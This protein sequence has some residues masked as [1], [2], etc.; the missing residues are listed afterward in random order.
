[1]IMKIVL[2]LLLAGGVL[3]VTDRAQAQQPIK[4]ECS[5]PDQCFYID[6]ELAAKMGKPSDYPQYASLGKRFDTNGERAFVF[7]PRYKEWAAY[8]KEGYL[9]A[10]GVA[11][12][13]A[14]SCPDLGGR[15][16][17]TPMGVFRV[18]SKGSPE[19]V[20]KKFPIG[21]G[22]AAMPYCMYF[23][24]GYAIHGSPYISDRNGSHGC[25]RV[26]TQAARWLSQYFIQPGTKVIVLPY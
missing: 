1:M 21:I 19:C 14:D 15:R 3:W 6:G 11:N 16:C 25:I 23:N 8:D 20:S 7:S 24:S 22:G 5:N 13:G 17:H 10:Q 26:H 2:P 4:D 12:G 18:Q 9:V